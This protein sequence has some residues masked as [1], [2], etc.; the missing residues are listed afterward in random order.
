MLEIYNFSKIY[1]K[2]SIQ[3]RFVLQI[4]AKTVDSVIQSVQVHISALVNLDVQDMIALTVILLR[5][6]QKRRRPLA[7][8]SIRISVSTMPLWD[9]VP[10]TMLISTSLRLERVVRLL[11]TLVMQS[12][13]DHRVVQILKQTV[14]IGLINAI[15]FLIP[16][17]VPG[18]ATCVRGFKLF[19]TFIITLQLQLI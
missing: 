13:P 8:T 10:Y 7:S 9:I 4:H 6:P 18:R 15:A 17:R 1:N 16:I 3:I 19:T 5:R 14:F 11:V 2:I 12:L